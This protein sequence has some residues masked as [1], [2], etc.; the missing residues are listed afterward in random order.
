MVLFLLYYF[1]FLG[2]DKNDKRSKYDL[3]GAGSIYN[4][5]IR[6]AVY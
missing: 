4:K 6:E 1:L 5:A 2:L 3:R